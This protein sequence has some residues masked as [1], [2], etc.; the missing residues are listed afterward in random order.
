MQIL[1]KLKFLLLILYFSFVNSQEIPNEFLDYHIKKFSTDMGNNWSGHST[2][3]PIRYK[4]MNLANDSLIIKS[5][6]GMMIDNNRKSFYAFGH[7]LYK[8]NFHGYLYPRVVNKSNLFD[9]Y[10]GIPRGINRGW[11]NSGETDLS[12]IAYENNWLLM[13]FGRGRQSWGAGNDIELA[14]SEQSNAYDYGM[15]DLDFGQL[16][17]RYFHGYLETD[18]LFYNRY[19]TGRGIEW[20]NQRNFIFSLSEIVIYSGLNRPLDFAYMNPIATHLEIELNDRQNNIG[21]GSGNGIW[22]ISFDYLLLKKIIISGNY[23]IDEYTLDSEQLDSG[24]G[25]GRAYSYKIVYSIIN[26]SKIAAK[27]YFSNIS[28]G[29][30]TFK[31]QL[32]N[33]NFV[34]RNKP[35]G[36]QIGSDSRESKFGLKTMLN[37]KLFVNMEFGARA[38]GEKNFINDLYIGYTDYLDGPFPSGK[39]ENI[40][41]ISSEFKWWLKDYIAIFGEY[42]FT[43]SSKTKEKIYILNFGFNIFYSIKQKF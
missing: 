11:F 3:G 2:F 18:S 22:Q 26:Q 13:Q 4:K 29:T 42:H 10:S 6:F 20:N 7:F 32:G 12:G 37:K 25:D 43:N 33:N 34:Q 27:L 41:F 5:R 21:T 39:V 40:S 9:R 1:N 38:I 28:V 8:N 19:I 35:L 16:K 36:W 23:L 15:L 24:K 14:L 17:V 31:H 30:N